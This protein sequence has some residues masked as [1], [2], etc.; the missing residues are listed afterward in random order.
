MPDSPAF[1][2]LYTQTRT[3]TRTQAYDEQEKTWTGTW[4]RSMD[5][6]MHREHGDV[7]AP[8]MP[9]C[10]NADKKCSPASLLFH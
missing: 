6:N 4:T 9:E 2:P 3:C 8:L 7:Q 5:M 10:W 1:R